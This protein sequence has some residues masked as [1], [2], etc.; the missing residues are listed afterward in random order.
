MSH[1]EKQPLVK[2][3]GRGIDDG[4][5]ESGPDSSELFVF[6]RA[7][8][9]TTAESEVLLEKFG[10]NELPEKVVP[11]WYIFLSLFWQPMPIMIWIASG[12][13]NFLV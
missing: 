5:A 6:C 10:K 3:V 7:D 8:G 11:K 4:E 2:K 1:E 9:L 12:K 13:Y